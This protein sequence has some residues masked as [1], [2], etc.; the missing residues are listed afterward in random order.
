MNRETHRVLLT[1]S[2]P[3]RAL[4]LVP[5]CALSDCHP[6][7]NKRGRDAHRNSHCPGING[8]L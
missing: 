6:D 1:N 2:G 8:T 4:I 7:P 3:S 5:I